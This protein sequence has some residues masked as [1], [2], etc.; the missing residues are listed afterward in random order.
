MSGTG[1][2]RVP[3][4]WHITLN[5]KYIISTMM[6]HHSFHKVR[7]CLESCVANVC[8]LFKYSIPECMGAWPLFLNPNA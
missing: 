2:N 3:Q 4:L 5:D 1:R 6:V 8:N 7:L